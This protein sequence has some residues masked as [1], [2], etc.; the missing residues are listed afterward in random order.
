MTDSASTLTPKRITEDY[1]RHFNQVYGRT[2]SILHL[3]GPWYEVNGE[4]VHRFAL[5]TEINRL[6]TMTPPPARRPSAD[7]NVINR[8]IARLRGI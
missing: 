8:L 1:Q 3:G 5:L 7:R 6:K 2:P 4:T